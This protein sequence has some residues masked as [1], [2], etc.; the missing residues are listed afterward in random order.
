ME[1]AVTDFPEPL[2]PTKARV[3]PRL[4]SKLTPSSTRCFRLPVTN[5]TARSRTSMRVLDSVMSFPRIEGIACRFADKHQ[6]AEHE[7]EHGKGADTE[8]G[9]LQIGFALGHQFTQ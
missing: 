1:C 9:R 2:S 6:Q 3:S 7:G 4:M 8:P 5:S